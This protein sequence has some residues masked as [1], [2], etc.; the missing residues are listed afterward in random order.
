[1][2]WPEFEGCAEG[3]LSWEVRLTLLSFFILLL[4]LLYPTSIC[5]MKYRI[6]KD[7]KQIV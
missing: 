2:N 4:L 6:A 1:L 7:L 5:R 3:S